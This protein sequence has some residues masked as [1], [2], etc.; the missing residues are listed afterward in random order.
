MTENP[1]QVQTAFDFMYT[2]EVMV[3]HSGVSGTFKACAFPPER[4]D[5][6]SEADATS[7]LLKMQLQIRKFGDGAW[8]F[9]T[10][11]QIGD[12]V[13]TVD[14]KQWRITDVVYFDDCYTIEARSID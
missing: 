9:E 12:V 7:G 2:D 1:W 13:T 10:A 14:T 8:N 11:P 6:F 3:S 5:P 4:V